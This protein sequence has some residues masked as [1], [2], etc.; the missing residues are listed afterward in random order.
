MLWL[1][2]LMGLM[3]MGAAAYVDV[4]TYDLEDDDSLPDEDPSAPQRSANILLGTEGSDAVSGS[5][6][7]D[8][9]AARAGDDLVAAGDGDDEVHGEEGNDLLDGEDGADSLKGGDGSDLMLG[10]TGG[11]DLTGQND[12]DFLLG[13][14]GDDS[15][16]GSDGNDL[17]SGG[18]GDDTLSG[19]LGQDVLHGGAGADLLFGGA[20]DDTLIG[21]EPDGADDQTVDHLNGGG[22][23]DVIVAGSG[24]MIHGGR[25]ND[26]VVLRDWLENGAAAQISDFTAEEDSLLF[27]WDDAPEGSTAPEV[28]VLADPGNAGQLQVW[29]GEE[30]VA[31]VRGGQM[32]DTAEIALVPLSAAKALDLMRADPSPE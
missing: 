14:A 15:L 11:D 19:G 12:D 3:A 22:A 2:G 5:E 10:G 30:V 1:A 29:L 21:I 24:D 31:Q 8:R 17:L 7:P 25:G 18:D 16:N 9:I 27:V 26:D 6:A 23:D 4:G 28:Q 20:G 32:L 13:G